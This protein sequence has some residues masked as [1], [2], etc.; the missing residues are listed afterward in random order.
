MYILYKALRSAGGIRHPLR[1]LREEKLVWSGQRE[2]PKAC[3]IA[4]ANWRL[5]NAKSPAAMLQENNPQTPHAWVY[6]A[7]SCMYL[8]G[9]CICDVYTSVEACDYSELSSSLGWRIGTGTGCA[10]CRWVEKTVFNTQQEHVVDV[11]AKRRLFL[12]ASL[13]P[14]FNTK[15]SIV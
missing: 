9:I 1:L 5:E 7:L 14:I 12:V 6:R 10:G 13:T 15:H 4:S 8:P 2:G 11:T 3:L